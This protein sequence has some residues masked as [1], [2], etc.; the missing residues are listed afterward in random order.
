MTSRQ[1][2][3]YRLANQLISKE[4]TT[5]PED[6]VRRMGCVQAQDFAGAKWAIGE[7]SARANEADIDRCFNLGSI[8]RTHVL[9]P[10]WHFV[11]PEDIGWMLK[12][13]A[14]K[15]KALSRG[16]H[17]KLGIDQPTLKRSKQVIARV[18]TDAKQLTR[19]QIGLHLK[20]ARLNTDDIR[21]SF[22]LMDAELDGII[23]SGGR[24][25]KQFTYALLEE[26]APHPVH[27]DQDA[28]IA[29]LGRR[30]F[31]SRGPATVYDFAWWGGLSISQ[32]QRGLEMNRA[33]LTHTVLRGQAY[34]YGKDRASPA[35]ARPSVYLLPAYDEYT[36]A[37]RDR[38]DILSPE[39]SEATGHGIFRPILVVNG[40]VA[41]TW[42]GSGT[43]DKIGL[44]V[45]PLAP[46]GKTALRLLETAAVTYA[47][48]VQKELSSLEVKR[49][50]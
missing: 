29:E 31:L 37:Y 10:T 48:F 42:K 30:Y 40:Q 45:R 19:A 22:L 21:I 1:I 4:G 49:T 28:A 18:L 50:L 41:G 46:L 17:K 23:C 13:S 6:Q 39:A 24:E 25:G 34:W 2:A 14:P 32:A 33:K 3:Q 35:P 27:F 12:L 11:C 47:R 43:K 9:R 38:A 5:R 7:R 15:I 8:L 26:R 16:L 44:E 36:V 20:K